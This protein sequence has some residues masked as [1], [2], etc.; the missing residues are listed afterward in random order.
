MKETA[1]LAI[2]VR[3]Q[4]AY[5]QIRVLDLNINPVKRVFFLAINRYQDMVTI[6][7]IV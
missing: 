7:E 6:D 2:S 1:P 5:E 3:V 4:Q